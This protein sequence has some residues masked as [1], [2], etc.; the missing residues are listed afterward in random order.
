MYVKNCEQ[1]RTDETMQIIEDYFC[2]GEEPGN[3]D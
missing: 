1:Y 3:E 2:D